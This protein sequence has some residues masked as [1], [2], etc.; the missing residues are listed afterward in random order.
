[1][2]YF[3]SF[4]LNIFLCDWS[5]H[6]TWLNIL[7]LKLGNKQVTF[8]RFQNRACYK[9]YSKDNKHNDSLHLAKK[10]MHKYLSLDITVPV[11]EIV[12]PTHA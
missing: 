3:L 9:K 10:N 8:P 1:M 12:A 2:K 6:I 5:K 7:Q 11:K 4:F